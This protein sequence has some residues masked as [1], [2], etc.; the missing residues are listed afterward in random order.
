[1]LEL[2]VAILYQASFRLKPISYLFQPVVELGVG[3]VGPKLKNGILEQILQAKNPCSGFY[4]N[5][6]GQWPFFCQRFSFFTGCLVRFLYE[7]LPFWAP[8]GSLGLQIAGNSFLAL[9]LTPEAQ[10][11]HFLSAAVVAAAAAVF[12]RAVEFH[13]GFYEMEFL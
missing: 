11:A 4:Q 12:P 5:I 8:K 3:K 9:F 2:I 6:F 10:L 7:V 13:G 1:M